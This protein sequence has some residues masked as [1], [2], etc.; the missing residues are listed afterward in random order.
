MKK[1][2]NRELCPG[3]AALGILLLLILQ[4]SASTKGVLAGLESCAFQV[5]PALFPFFVVTFWYAGWAPA[6]PSW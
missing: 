4:P 5:I 3:A 6:R 2:G 1:Y